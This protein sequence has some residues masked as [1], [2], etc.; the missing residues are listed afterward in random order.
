MN[1]AYPRSFR[2]FA[3]LDD[4]Y[5]DGLTFAEPLDARPLKSRDVDEHILSAAIRSDETVAPLGIEPF[6]R[7]G[8]LDR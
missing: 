2:T 6:H 7:A 8:L 3:A 5:N 1:Q 4:I